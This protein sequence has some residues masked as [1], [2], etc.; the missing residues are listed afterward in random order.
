MNPLLTYS[1]KFQDRHIGPNAD[2]LHRMLAT[3][4]VRSLD[5]LVDE[6]V[7]HAIRL[8]QPLELKPAMTETEFLAHVGSLAKKNLV[9]KSYIGMGY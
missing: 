6:T 5:E 3:T 9:F 7:P 2:D 8:K 1:E 4:G